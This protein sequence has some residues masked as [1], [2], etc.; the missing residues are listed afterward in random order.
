M[1]FKKKT[2]KESLN[3]EK[4]EKNTYSKNPQNIILSEDQFERLISNLT[5]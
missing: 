3:I 4:K 2:I 5:K 1:K